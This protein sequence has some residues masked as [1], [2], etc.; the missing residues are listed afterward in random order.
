M[1]NIL[2]DFIIPSLHAQFS[3]PNCLN[4]LIVNNAYKEVQHILVS[5]YRHN[6]A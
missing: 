2:K 5:S 6:L 1:V 3:V 4:I